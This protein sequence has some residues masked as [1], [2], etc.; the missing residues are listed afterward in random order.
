VS[1]DTQGALAPLK[2]FLAIFLTVW[3]VVFAYLGFTNGG[4]LMVVFLV[5]AVVCLAVGV[6]FFRSFAFV[7]G[8]EF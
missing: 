4:T 7:H 5:A 6:Y 1:T 3:A 2:R 8:K